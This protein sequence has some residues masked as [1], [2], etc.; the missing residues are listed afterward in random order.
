MTL[1]KDRPTRIGYALVDADL[2]EHEAEAGGAFDDWY[3]AVTDVRDEHVERAH[4]DV[5]S[6]GGGG[7]VGFVGRR[8]SGV[9]SPRV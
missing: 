3:E 7:V 1:R 5:P 6:E 8:M 4:G 9:D 2:V